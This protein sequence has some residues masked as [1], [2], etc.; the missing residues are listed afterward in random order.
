MGGG[1]GWI[2]PSCYRLTLFSPASRSPKGNN[3]G[4]LEWFAV[5]GNNEKIS[6]ERSLRS[7]GKQFSCKLFIKVNNMRMLKVGL[8][9]PA[10]GRM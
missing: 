3:N 8:I 9:S 6:T 5:P 7:R 10:E 4:R 2:A 1:R